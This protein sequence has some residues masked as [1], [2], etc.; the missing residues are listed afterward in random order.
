MAPRRR[1]PAW[2][3]S[4]DGASV[5]SSVLW[6]NHPRTIRIGQG[7][8]IAGPF[9]VLVMSDTS[10]NSL[11]IRWTIGSSLVQ[12]VNGRRGIQERVGHDTAGYHGV[13]ANGC[14]ALQPDGTGEIAHDSCNMPDVSG[15]GP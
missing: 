4:S 5:P 7:T 2:F 15:G 1:I 12:S 9:S 3:I 13:A 6:T 11:L 8:I 14:P 10:G